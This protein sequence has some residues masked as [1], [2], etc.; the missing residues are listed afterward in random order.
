MCNEFAQEKTWEQY[1]ELMARGA[2][3]IFSEPP[4]DLPFGSIRPSERAA[5]L[6]AGPPGSGGG[7]AGTRLELIPWGW[8]PPG[9]KGL[10]I[11]IQSE[12]RRDPPALRGIAP[13]DRFY[14]FR[15]DNP[16]QKGALKSK[17][18]FTP[19]VNEPLGFA[20][21]VN[22]G[23]FALLTTAP[24]PDVAPIHGRMP[25]TLRLRDWRRFLTAAAW[26]A[27]LTAPAAEGTL[28]ALQVR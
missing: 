22:N 18:A 17:F 1:C 13:M 8:T 20:V 5:I 23:R 21:I 11:N 6:G 12:K 9:G 7:G 10:V 26:P 14:E 15:G 2:A 19:A 16:P 27:D 28:Q 4:P 3:E 24:N 25:V